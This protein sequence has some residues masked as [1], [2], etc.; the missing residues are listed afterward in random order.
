[1]MA[2]NAGFDRQ[3]SKKGFEKNEL[4]CRVKGV[5]WFQ[6]GLPVSI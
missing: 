5:L 6:I 1:M 4:A 2:E 3:N